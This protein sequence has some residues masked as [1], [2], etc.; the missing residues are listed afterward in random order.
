MRKLLI[1]GAGEMQVPII[2]KAKERGIYTIVAD[3]NPEAPGMRYANKAIT[4]STLDSSSLLQYALEEKIDG[5]LT[6]SDAPVTVVA[7]IA[8]KLGLPAMS[9]KVALICTNKYQ[10]RKYF[11]QHG[12]S[13]PFFVVCKNERELFGLNDFPYIV[14]PVD[15]SA[16]RGVTKVDNFQDLLSAFK[17]A[18]LFSRSGQVIIESFIGGRE[19]SVE[20]YTQAGKTNII[21]VTEKFVIGEN[22][23]FFVED[24]HLEPARISSKEYDLI[25]TEV[26]KVIEKIGLDNS[27]SHTEVKLNSNGVFVIEIA[28]RLGGD[29]ITSDLVP[30]STGISMLDNMINVAL[31]DPI[32]FSP[33]FHKCS[34]V[35]FLN[36]DNY[37]RCIQFINSENSAIRRWEVKPYSS[38]LIKSSLDRLG[39]IIL[40]TE[41]MDKLEL[42]LQQIK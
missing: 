13:T 12:I 3:M 16:S 35:Q 31:G 14:K 30:L 19:F 40:Q 20:T 7:Y 8:E 27:P 42:I 6:T 41:Q 34:A 2:L 38:K 11:S 26:L 4:I 21:A 5:V 1:L 10:Q 23:G 39:Y 17:F 22:V 37:E 9:S 24:A 18:L 25:S 36:T 28:C 29:Y 15:S 33:S 32:N